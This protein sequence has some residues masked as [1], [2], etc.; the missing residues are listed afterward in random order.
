MLR[1]AM[2]VHPFPFVGN[3]IFQHITKVTCMALLPSQKGAQ[4]YH[5]IQGK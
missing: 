4:A 3:H 2:K 1:L 5:K